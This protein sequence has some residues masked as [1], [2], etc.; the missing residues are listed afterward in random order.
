MTQKITV[1]FL[2]IIPIYAVQKWKLLW[3]KDEKGEKH[4]N[5]HLI[6]S[7]TT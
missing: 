1:I 2:R 3:K 4:A 5:D 7:A 6:Q